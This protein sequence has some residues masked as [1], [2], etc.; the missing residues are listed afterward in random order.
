MSAVDPRK[1]I[2]QALDSLTTITQLSESANSPTNLMAEH[3]LS[4]QPLNNPGA[5][6]EWS[7]SDPLK[8]AGRPSPGHGATPINAVFRSG[9]Q[10]LLADFGGKVKVSSGTRSDAEQTALWNQALKKYGSPEAARKWVAPPGNSNHNRGIAADLSFADDAT[11]RAVHAN[12][13]KYGL[14]FP[15]SNEIWHIEPLGSR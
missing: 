8:N 10:K 2:Q 6:G 13:K 4:R 5:M 1:Y 12:A 3:N 15:L 11:L 14:H 7:D 9:L